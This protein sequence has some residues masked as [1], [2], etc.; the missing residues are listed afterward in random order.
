MS[1]IGTWLVVVFFCPIL[2]HA[3]ESYPDFDREYWVQQQDLADGKIKRGAGLGVLGLV[4][5]WPASM[6]I[7]RAKERPQKYF[8]LSTVFC[9]STLGA[10][11][12]GFGSVGYGGKQRDAAAGFV[13]EY[14]FNPGSVSIDAQQSEVLHSQRKTARKVMLFGGFL[15]AEALVLLTNGGVQSVRKGRGEDMK[16][17]RIWPYYLSGGLLLAAGIGIVIKSKR[18]L[19]DVK[20]LEHSTTIP[21]Q[22]GISPFYGTTENGNSIFGVSLGTSF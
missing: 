15:A 11:L 2:L 12:H 18:T 20:S 8:A 10:I 3:Q 13:G 4:A 9:L 16:D 21:T 1:K 14:D 17:I 22:A 7:V 5:V 19:D 6:M